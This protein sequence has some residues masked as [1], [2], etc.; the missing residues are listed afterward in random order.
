MLKLLGSLVAMAITFGP[1][2]ASAQ[3]Y[4]VRPITMI[5]PFAAGGATDVIA[6]IVAEGM[7]ED[8]GQRVIVENAGGAGGTAGSMRAMRADP[9][10]YTILTGHMG[11]HASVYSLYAK[12][13][14]D[15]RT[16]FQPVGL[17]AS[18]PIVVFARKDFPADNL[19]TFVAHLKSSGEATKVAHSGVGSNAHLTCLLLNQ[20]V[21]AKPTEVAYRGNGPLM[22]DLMS[23]TV[24]YSCDQVIT[25]APQV[26]A[27]TVKALV[28]AS[29]VRSNT[30]PNVPTSAEAGLPGYVADA[31]TAIFAP[32]NTPEDV[33]KRLNEAYARALDNP[34]VTVRLA[35][36]GAVVPTPDQRTRAHLKRVVEND[37][38]RWADVLSK[39]NIKLD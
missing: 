23:G 17:A 34:K 10:G 22:T 21:G 39:T 35:E 27:G 8:L 1:G 13:K 24:D 4:P 15:P 2:L 16:D 7:S 19:P 32:A 36:L 11:T 33:L 31:W 37:V 12:P 26:A 6:R 38:A 5:V 25:V 30:I 28:V 20:L 18:A 14:Y 9:D 3:P 29:P